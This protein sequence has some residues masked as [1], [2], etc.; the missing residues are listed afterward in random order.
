MDFPMRQILPSSPYVPHTQVPREW[1]CCLPKCQSYNTASATQ[2]S[3]CKHEKC[4]E[5][6][7]PTYSILHREVSGLMWICCQCGDGP[8]VYTRQSACIE[9]H[10]YSC[11]SCT[12]VK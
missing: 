5:C 12:L 2:C 11:A 3:E 4:A 9:C 10:H 6:R 7:G 8:K 1:Y